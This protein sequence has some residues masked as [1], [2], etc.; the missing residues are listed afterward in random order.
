MDQQQSVNSQQMQRRVPFHRPSI[1]DAEIDEVVDTLRSGWLT[2]GPKAALFTEQFC[3]AVEAP[4]GLAVSSCTAALHLGLL[5]AGIGPGDVVFTTPVT[6]AATVQVI[7]HTGATPVLVDVDPETLNID[8]E[9]LRAAV[10][11]TTLGRPAA[12]MPVHLA[13]HPCDMDEIVAVAR[14][15]GMAVI[16]DA[17]HSLPASYKN[18]PIGSIRSEVAHMVAFSFY[19]TKNLGIGEGGMLT[20]DATTIE[21]ARA[22]CLHGMSKDAWRR[23]AGG[24]WFYDI[25]AE[26]YK[27]NFTDIQAAIGLHQL[28][29]LDEMQRR[30]LEIVQ[31]YHEAFEPIPALQPPTERPDVSSAWHLYVLRLD[32]TQLT[33][34]RAGFIDELEQ[35]QVSTSVHFIPIHHH[36]YFGKVIDLAP[37]AL[38][39]AD[40][41]FSRYLSLPLYPS[42]TQDDID[43]VVTAVLDVVERH[44]P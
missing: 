39:V 33:I 38:P 5:A 35:R 14:D 13:G 6:F 10:E 30:R 18:R 17:A 27:Y 3:A 16:E 25:V 22:L 21:D 32:L 44:A 37:G 8:P 2:T 26:G 36:S 34:D 4:A 19:A 41:E 1:T 12:V 29:R 31:Q 9:A 15:H 7:L 20:A 24:N 11:S 42:M 40:R 43:S 28:A 23:Y